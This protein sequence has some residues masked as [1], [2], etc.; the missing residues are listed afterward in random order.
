[1]L[2]GA[3]KHLCHRCRLCYLSGEAKERQQR[4][5]KISIVHFV[6]IRFTRGQFWH[7]K[8]CSSP[9]KRRLTDTCKGDRLLRNSLLRKSFWSSSFA[10]VS[11]LVLK[12][13]VP[14]IVREG[15]FG[16]PQQLAPTTCVWLEVETQDVHKEE[17]NYC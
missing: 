15:S 7:V 1:M 11:V 14:F 8:V 3:N 12:S 9:C 4:P 5:P 10:F 17:E 2:V 13:F 6:M 16:T